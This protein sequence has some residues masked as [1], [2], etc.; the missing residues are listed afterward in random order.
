MGFA[1][2]IPRASVTLE[3]R[4]V[5][6]LGEREA[7]LLEAVERVHSLKEAAREAGISYR[8]AWGAIRL[9]EQALGEPMVASRAGG[10]GGGSSTLT[11]DGRRLV[12]LYRGLRGRLEE[13][14]ARARD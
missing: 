7:C 5:P 1:D 13:E 6:V 14:L 11:D 8:T 3:R 9:M 4:G 10:P 2:L 12:Q